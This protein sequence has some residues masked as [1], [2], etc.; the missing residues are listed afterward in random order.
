MKRE[1]REKKRKNERDY[2]DYLELEIVCVLLA[3]H[4]NERASMLAALWQQPSG[5]RDPLKATRSSIWASSQGKE[6]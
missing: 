5:P 1:K 2:L 3:P 4:K 6:K